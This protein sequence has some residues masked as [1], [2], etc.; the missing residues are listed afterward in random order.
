MVP[1]FVSNIS[2]IAVF[3]V[4]VL[5]IC[6]NSPVIA[7]NHS[8]IK[9]LL[10]LEIIIEISFRHHHMLRWMDLSVHCVVW[11][12]CTETY[13]PLSPRPLRL[14]SS[15]HT[16]GLHESIRLWISLCSGKG[17][18]LH[19]EKKKKNM[20]C[21]QNSATTLYIWQNALWAFFNLLQCI[22]GI[23]ESTGYTFIHGYKMGK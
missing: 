14:L 1:L 20:P 17:S 5:Y 13:P 3:E 7:L 23:Y 12:G 9:E 16:A 2:F 21:V 15:S 6:V 22:V 11:M 18:P 8:E 10:F 4:M 19:A